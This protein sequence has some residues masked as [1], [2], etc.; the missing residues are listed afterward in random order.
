MCVLG[1]EYHCIFEC[2]ISDR[3]RHILPKHFVTRPN[4]FE[5]LTLFTSTHGPTVRKL[6]NFLFF[7]KPSIFFVIYHYYYYY[8]YFFFFNV[9]LLI[10]YYVLFSFLNSHK[11]IERAV[12]C[13]CSFLI[14]VVFWTGTSFVHIAVFVL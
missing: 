6:A 14:P 2:P 8:Y 5:L 12:L 11:Y 9:I 1:D 7:S 3:F 13:I 10:I 4:M